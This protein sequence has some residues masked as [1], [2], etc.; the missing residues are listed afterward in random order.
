MSKVRKT[1]GML[2]NQ[3][4]KKDLLDKAEN[5]EDT[6]NNKQEK[7]QVQHSETQEQT[8]QTQTVSNADAIQPPETTRRKQESNQNQTQ[9]QSE[10]NQPWTSPNNPRLS[11]PKHDKSVKYNVNPI[12]QMKKGQ[13]ARPS[14]TQFRNKG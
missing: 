5:Y 11:K 10:R 13:T 1:A 12:A 2:Q 6:A 14:A 4:Q 9:Q 3:K 8:H 7:P